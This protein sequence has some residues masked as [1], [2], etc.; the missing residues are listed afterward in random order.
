MGLRSRIIGTGSYLPEKVLSNHDLESMLDTSDE[1]IRTRTGMSERRVAADDETSSTMGVEAARR[2]LKDAGVKAKELDLILVATGTPDMLFPSTACI[3]QKEI[4][5][6]KAVGF[7]ISAACSGFIYALSV[8]DQYIK[9][10]MYK[11]ILVVG[12]DLL[13]RFLDWTDRSSCILFGDGAGAVIL[14]AEDNGDKGILSTHIYSDGTYGGHLYLKGGGSSGR[15]SH[16]AIDSKENLLKMQGNA[17]FKIAIRKMVEVVGEALA[18]NGKVIS[19]VDI[20]VPH[21]ANMRIIKAVGEGIGLP[22]EKVF[23]NIEKYGNT[24]AATIPIALDE[25]VK[26]GRLNRDDLLLL[27][28]FGGGMTWGSALV[29][30]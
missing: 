3:I 18:A 26:E 29:S 5:A 27:V 16:E 21:Q 19:D 24:M 28:A 23:V 14:S 10:G 13:T 1:W 2:A 9:T 30:W 8:A 6:V 20:L 17:T 4:G 25:A 22:P 15:L 7:D 11:K 12:T